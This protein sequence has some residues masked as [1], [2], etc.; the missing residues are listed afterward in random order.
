MSRKRLSSVRRT[1]PGAVARAASGGEGF[2]EKMIRCRQVCMSTK[3][4]E[5]ILHSGLKLGGGLSAPFHMSDPDCRNVRAA[6]CTP[7]PIRA[8]R[9]CEG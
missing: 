5:N 2:S 9:S 6:K 7:P 3:W 1:V 4:A 8:T